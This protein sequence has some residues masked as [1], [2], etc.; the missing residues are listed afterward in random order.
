MFG[1]G[2]NNLVK[3]MGKCVLF[4]IKTGW[5]HAEIAFAVFV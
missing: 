2:S 3:N 5:C 4:I 1:R